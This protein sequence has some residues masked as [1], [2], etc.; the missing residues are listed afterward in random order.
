MVSFMLSSIIGVFAAIG[1][2]LSHPTD[3][4]LSTR[5]TPAA[6]HFVIYSDEWVSGENGPPPVSDVTV[7]LSLM[8]Y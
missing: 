4:T 2:A 1:G 7:S 3:Q 8:V 5:A 6:P